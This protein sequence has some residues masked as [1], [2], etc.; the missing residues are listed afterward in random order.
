[1]FSN[2]KKKSFFTEELSNR[3]GIQIPVGAR[4]SS[5]I[6]GF[7]RD[8]FWGITRRRVIPQ[9]TADF[10]RIFSFPKRPDRL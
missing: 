1:M 9:K 3:S 8:V 4:E 7:R 6:S 5:L 10:K 2:A